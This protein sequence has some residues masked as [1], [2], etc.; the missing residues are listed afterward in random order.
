VLG[1]QR[2]P[3]CAKC[4]GLTDGKACF[5]CGALVRAESPPA[6][7]TLVIGL[8]IGGIFGSAITASVVL[9]L[10]SPPAPPPDAIIPPPPPVVPVK[11]APPAQ[12]RLPEVIRPPV[13]REPRRTPEKGGFGKFACATKPA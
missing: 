10:L 2:Y 4:R 6:A 12:P 11:P 3:P 5:S 1:L 8:G 7:R 9:L 13:D